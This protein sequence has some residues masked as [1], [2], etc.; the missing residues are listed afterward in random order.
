MWPIFL[1]SK[2]N[3]CS[4]Y[5][6]I[7][8]F[9]L[10]LVASH[11]PDSPPHVA[12]DCGLHANAVCHVLQCLDLSRDHHGLCS[13]LFHLLPFCGSHVIVRT[14]QEEDD[15][16]WHFFPMTRRFKNLTLRT[17]N[18]KTTLT[19]LRII[20]MHPICVE[21]EQMGNFA[22]ELVAQHL[23]HKSTMIVKDSSPFCVFCMKRTTVIL[24][25]VLV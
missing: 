16:F 21:G 8:L 25:H 5:L 6:C 19:F 7:H 17:L 10:Q 3:A 2:L 13:W 22:K 24:R 23:S 4:N 15:I 11:Y 12:G 1:I 14:L 18:L 20:P 9:A